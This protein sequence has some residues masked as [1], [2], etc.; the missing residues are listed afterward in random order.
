VADLL[1]LRG[2]SSAGGIDLAAALQVTFD[3]LWRGTRWPEDVAAPA[4]AGGPA[5]YAL[6]TILTDR[7]IR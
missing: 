6:I 7:V 5:E 2:V 1:S 3:L 4:G